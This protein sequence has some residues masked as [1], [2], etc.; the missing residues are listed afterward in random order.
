MIFAVPQPPNSQP[1]M[2]KVQLW[3]GLQPANRESRVGSKERHFRKLRD[4]RANCWRRLADHWPWLLLRDGQK[5]LCRQALR[6]RRKHGIYDS[7]RHTERHPAL[8]LHL[9]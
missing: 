7:K 1:A 9:S 3:P 6:T 2:E 8:S 4:V 5:F